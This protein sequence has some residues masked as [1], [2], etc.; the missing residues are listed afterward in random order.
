LKIN[1]QKSILIA[2]LEVLHQEEL[3]NILSCI[4][5]SLPLIYLGFLLGASF[6]SKAIWDG[7]VEKMERRFTCL[8]AVA[9]SHQE[10]VI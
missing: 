8:G 5:S 6:K 7:V 3:A 10:H 4:I 2:V 1:L 9:Y